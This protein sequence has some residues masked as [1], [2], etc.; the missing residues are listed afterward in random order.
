MPAA[1]TRIAPIDMPV[2]LA[3]FDLPG[4][5]GLLHGGG[6]TSWP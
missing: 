6:D 2:M 4:T 3:M 1:I 5:D